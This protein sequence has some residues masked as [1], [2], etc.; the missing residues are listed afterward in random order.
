M[1]TAKSNR[2]PLAVSEMDYWD[3]HKLASPCFDPYCTVCTI[4]AELFATLEFHA[5]VTWTRV[6]P[7]G[8]V[9]VVKVAIPRLSCAVPRTVAPAVKVTG[10]VT[11]TV[12]EVILAVNVTACPR[13]EGFGEDVM[14]AVLVVCFTT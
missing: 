11:V 13:V 10:P 12:G 5:W 4:E 7:V 9:E 1:G 6:D 14:V 2:H 3:A 8:S